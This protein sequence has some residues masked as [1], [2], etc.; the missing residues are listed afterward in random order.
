MRN[1]CHVACEKPSEPTLCVSYT[2][3]FYCLFAK[4]CCVIMSITIKTFIT[5][6][7]KFCKSASEAVL[8]AITIFTFSFLLP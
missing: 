4:S 8:T 1:R 7:C 2:L 5:A 6:K 3:L